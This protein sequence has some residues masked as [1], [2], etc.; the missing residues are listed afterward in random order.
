V[1]E[2]Q[3]TSHIKIRKKFT[4]VIGYYPQ[5]D[6]SPTPFYPEGGSI[7]KITTK[8]PFQEGDYF[9]FQ[10]KSSKV[11]N[12]VAKNSLD[13][14]GVVPNPYIASAN[15]ERKTISANGRGERRIDFINLPATCTVRI[16]TVA[17][18]L[19]KTL[20]KESGPLDGSLSWNLLS[21]DGMDVAYGLYIFHVDAPGIGE[22]IGKFAL[23][24]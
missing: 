7:F 23:I 10:T 9:T 4:W 8:K 1:I 13:R 19:V 5:N 16:Y 17:G 24:K 18:A 21:E 15:W 6:G 2:F 3:F 22:K 20:H 11:D 14:I 12:S